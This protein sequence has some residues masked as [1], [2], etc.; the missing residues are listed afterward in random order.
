MYDIED[1][2]RMFYYGKNFDVTVR[3]NCAM[4]IRITNNK[5]DACASTSKRDGAF[6]AH[7]R[8]VLEYII[9]VLDE[10]AREI[11]RVDVMRNK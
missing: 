8:A 7:E 11:V 1:S 2:A 5:H 4:S 6:C 3:D 10:I 9:S